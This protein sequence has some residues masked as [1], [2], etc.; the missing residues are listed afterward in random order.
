MQSIFW[1]CSSISVTFFCDSAR[2][3]F[4]SLRNASIWHWVKLKS[5]GS[6]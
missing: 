2:M 1:I 5:S 4:C 6:S 3:R